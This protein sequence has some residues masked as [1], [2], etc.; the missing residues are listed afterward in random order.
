MGA[1]SA[2]TLS[3]RTASR[4]GAIVGCGRTNQ[5]SARSSW[6]SAS[7]T[8]R[9]SLVCSP[10]KSRHSIS[11]APGSPGAPKSMRRRQRVERAS[12]PVHDAPD[13]P[14]RGLQSR[15]RDLHEQCRVL[16]RSHASGRDRAPP[17]SRRPVPCSLR[18]RERLAEDYRRD[19]NG[20]QVDLVVAL[21]MRNKPSVDFC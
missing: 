14:P 5:A 18:A 9:R 16:F 2:A 17:S 10:P 1:I 7:A 13:Q 4:T 6:S 3:Q 12:W 15:G 19:P 21:A 20:S 8:E 11:S